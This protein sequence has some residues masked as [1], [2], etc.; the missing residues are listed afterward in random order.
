M[1]PRHF[2]AVLTVSALSAVAA[3]ASGNRGYPATSSPSASQQEER[4]DDPVQLL[5]SRSPG[6]NVVRTGDGG[7][8]VQL[9]QAPS[10][11]NSGIEPLYVIDDVPFRPGPGGALTGV[12]PYDIQSIQVLRK[13]EEIGIYGLRGANG[14]IVIKTKKPGR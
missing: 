2:R 10:S 9:I 7:I 1:T 4:I 12:N 6:L 8:A 14:V 11:V 13:P 5:R 3:C